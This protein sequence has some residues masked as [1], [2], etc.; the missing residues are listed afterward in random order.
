MPKIPT[1][2]DLGLRQPS[3]N[4]GQVRDVPMVGRDTYGDVAR[5]AGNIASDISKQKA[6][7]ADR[8]N[9]SQLALA[10]AKLTTS[11][12]EEISKFDD[13]P[14]YQTYGDRFNQSMDQR[15]GQIYSEFEDESLAS[16]WQLLADE[17]VAQSGIKVGGKALS[18]ERVVKSDELD[19]MLFDLSKTMQSTGELGVIAAQGKEIIDSYADNLWEDNPDLKYRQWLQKSAVGWIKTLP[20]SQQLEAV[21]LPEVKKNLEPSTIATLQDNAK[22][23]AIKLQGEELA[24]DMIFRGIGADELN[25]ELNNI[26]DVS[27]RDETRRRFGVIQKQKTQA[28]DAERDGIVDE[29]YPAIATGKMNLS[30][31]PEDEIVKL[32]EDYKRLKGAEEAYLKPPSRSNPDVIAA[33]MEAGTNN[34]IDDMG[35]ILRAAQEDNSLR[36]TD[37][38]QYMKIY[39][40]LKAKKPSALFTAQSQFT[41]FTKNMDKQSAADLR[42]SLN[43][44]YVEYQQANDGLEPSDEWVTKT[45]HGLVNSFDTTPGGI[46]TDWFGVKPLYEMSDD[47]QRQQIEYLREKDY[48]TLNTALGN[49]YQSG[50]KPSNTD[51]LVEYERIKNGK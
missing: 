47:E 40:D 9:R 21:K 26:E 38:E 39:Y 8:R 42:T 43:Q 49:L 4:V 10:N 35:V 41:S 28:L 15:V 24:Q 37:L 25:Q 17:R 27:L 20:P 7:A 23:D 1:G 18:R 3:Q 32:G 12:N 6:V 19:G 33:L 51:V 31:V 22:K 5:L 34:R 11:L 45:M 36:D 30:D 29:Y 48:N 14:D 16:Q 46:L 2:E 50:I 44:K 13:D